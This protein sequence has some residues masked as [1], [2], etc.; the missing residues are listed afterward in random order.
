[1]HINVQHSRICIIRV[2]LIMWFSAAKFESSLKRFFFPPRFFSLA[3]RCISS[4]FMNSI[5]FSL[6]LF[7]SFFVC[8]YSFSPRRSVQTLEA[9][10][11]RYPHAG[12]D[13]GNEE[14]DGPQRPRGCGRQVAMARGTDGDLGCDTINASTTGRGRPDAA[15]G[16]DSTH[17]GGESLGREPGSPSPALPCAADSHRRC[18]AIFIVI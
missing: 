7:I 14:G 9:P 1:M 12:G 10:A 17:A 18:S 4:R 16:A 8:K 2:H 5:Y 11:S 6:H 15:G 13:P 3:L